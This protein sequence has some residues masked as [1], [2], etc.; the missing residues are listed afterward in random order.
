MISHRVFVLAITALSICDYACGRSTPTE[1]KDATVS[2]APPTKEVVAGVPTTDGIP[3]ECLTAITDLQHG[4]LYVDDP[5]VEIRAF[6]ASKLDSVPSVQAFQSTWKSAGCEKASGYNAVDASE[7]FFIEIHKKVCLQHHIDQ[8]PDAKVM[9]LRQAARMGNQ[10]A[11]DAYVLIAFCK[12]IT[13]GPPSQ[14]DPP[15]QAPQPGTTL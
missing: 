6:A 2:E 1:E 10:R 9:Q 8:V 3:K 15:A 5:Q 13:D 7:S 4:L 14:D 11:A 12:L